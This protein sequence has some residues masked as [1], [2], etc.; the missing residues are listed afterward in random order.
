MALHS[1]MCRPKPKTLKIFLKFWIEIARGQCSAMLLQAF[2]GKKLRNVTPA[3]HTKGPG[4][5][6]AENSTIRYR[7]EMLRIV[8]PNLNAETLA[9]HLRAVEMKKP[10]L[11][12]LKRTTPVGNLLLLL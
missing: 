5:A 10:S 9:G 11:S 12:P 3:Q 7:L 1:N 2:V 4:N 6:K 8:H